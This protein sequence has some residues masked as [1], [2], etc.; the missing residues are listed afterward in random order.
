[1]LV[2]VAVR[3]RVENNAHDRS[4]FNMSISQGHEE[5]MALWFWLQSFP[6]VSSAIIR[7]SIN[8]DERPEGFLN[9]I[10][11]CLDNNEIARYA[12]V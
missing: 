1:M 10:Q 8:L 2:P 3:K 7:A 6:L 5:L 9:F 12:S 4:N 11:T